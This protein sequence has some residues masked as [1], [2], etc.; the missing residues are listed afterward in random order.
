MYKCISNYPLY[1]F[2]QMLPVF[3]RQFEPYSTSLC[4]FVMFIFV[5][6]YFGLRDLL[7]RTTR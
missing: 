2:V 3:I 1:F 7:P 6:L 5:T 4:S